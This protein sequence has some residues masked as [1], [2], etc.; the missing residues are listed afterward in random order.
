MER[1]LS[2]PRDS[3]ARVRVKLTWAQVEAV[4]GGPDAFDVLIAGDEDSVEE[5]RVEQTGDD[6][7]IAQPQLAFAKEILPRRRWLQIC[8]RVPAAWKGDLDIATISGSLGAHG[9]AGDEVTLTTVSGPIHAHDI[10]SGHFAM[11]TATGTLAGDTIQANH[12][13]I[14]T[15]SGRVAVA[16]AR[17]TSAKVFTVSGEVSLAL[18]DGAKT[19][20]LQSVSGAMRVETD[21]PVLAALHSLSGQLSLDESLAARDGIIENVKNILEITASS[22]TGDLAVRRRE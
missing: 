21:T 3:I 5:L 20:D 8:L 4:S 19:L 18:A 16:E 15:V 7:S 2:F 9:I 1:N 13:Y 10:V 17:F 12:C 14:R 6:L 11:H 22:V